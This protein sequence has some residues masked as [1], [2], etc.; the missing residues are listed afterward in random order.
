MTAQFSEAPPRPRVALVLAHDLVRAGVQFALE[1]AGEFDVV[2]AGDR[3]DVHRI[4]ESPPQV[5]VIDAD[6]PDGSPSRE[7]EKVRAAAPRGATVALSIR[8]RNEL[9]QALRMRGVPQLVSFWAP[10][11]VLVDAVRRAALAA[12]AGV[13][14]AVPSE[15]RLAE[16]TPREREVL[17]LLA[18]ALPNK[19]IASSL[20]IS[21]STAKRHISNVYRKLGATSRVHAVL[22]GRGLGYVA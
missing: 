4:A 16:L 17:G 20:G 14:V 19:G 18:R 13:R 22:E 1:R 9:A 5:V 11:S 6:G 3:V 21:D 15:T 8:P 2:L 10:Q 7:L 12:N